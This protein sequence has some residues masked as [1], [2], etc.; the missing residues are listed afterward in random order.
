MLTTD[1]DG[2][3]TTTF[4]GQTLS[5]SFLDSGSNGLYFPDSSLPNCGSTAVEM[6]FYCPTTTQ[7]FSATNEGENGNSTPVTFFT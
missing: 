5:S 6:Q 4:N 1:A 3:I 2:L 7:S